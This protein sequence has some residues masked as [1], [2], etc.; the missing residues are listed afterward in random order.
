[1][2]EVAVDQTIEE[3]TEFESALATRGVGVADNVD[4]AAVGQQMIKLRPIGQL[5]DPIQ[6]DQQ[7]P[8][9]I[10]GW[11]VE[12]IEVYRLL[13]II[14]AHT[15]DVALVTHRI[16]QLELLEHRGNR[17]KT[18]ADFWPG[19]DRDAQRRSVVKDKT[20]KRVRHQPLA[21]V[22]H[23][24]IDSGKMRQ[25]YLPFLIPHREIVPATII[26]IANTRYA[27]AIALDKRPRHH[28]D[29][30]APVPIM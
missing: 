20:K 18:L 28:C 5:V 24:E 2:I 19:L 23:K 7:Q 25:Q 30:R 4:G 15:H 10:L 6:V 9:Q 27:Y 8:S 17:C 13:A 16:D 3:M 12:A 26:E 29:L 11:R 21:P 14:G 22:G 1:M